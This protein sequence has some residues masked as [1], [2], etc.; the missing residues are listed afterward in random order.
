MR[1]RQILTEDDVEDFLRI[2]PKID[3]IDNHCRYFDGGIHRCCKMH[4]FD[5]EDE[6]HRHHCMCGKWF[7]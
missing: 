4:W 5:S 1:Y 3:M 7:R 2:C 6:A